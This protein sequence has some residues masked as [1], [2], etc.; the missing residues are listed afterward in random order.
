MRGLNDAGPHLVQCVY[1]TPAAQMSVDDQAFVDPGLWQPIYENI[2]LQEAVHQNCSA[3]SPQP[4]APQDNTQWRR[5][6]SHFG[7]QDSVHLANSDETG[8]SEYATCQDQM[9]EFSAAT[10]AAQPDTV[11]EVGFSYFNRQIICT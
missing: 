2:R 10:A 7:S 6:Q 4:W 8:Q 1:E 11:G 3:D 5:Q 9:P